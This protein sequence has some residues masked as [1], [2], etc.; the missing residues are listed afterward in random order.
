MLDR[1]LF[2]KLLILVLS[3]TAVSTSF[4]QQWTV[5]NLAG[6]G[7]EGFTPGEPPLDNGFANPG[8]ICRD[9]EGNIYFTVN[10]FD[11]GSGVSIFES[12]GIYKISADYSEI[13]MILD[14][15][16]SLTGVAVDNAGNV[17]FSKGAT[18]GTETDEY[19]LE[20]I[21][22]IQASDG[23]IIQFAGNGVD[24]IGSWPEEGA[25][26]TETPIG[27]AGALKIRVEEGKEFL[28]YCAT[29]QDNNFIQKIDI[30]DKRTFRVA[31]LPH[32]L[33]ADTY[34]DVGGG[35]P[36]LDTEI[37]LALGLAWDSQGNLYYS[38]AISDPSSSLV[39]G[40]YSI[41]KIVDGQI[42]NVAGNGTADYSGD[43][44]PALA[45]GLRKADGGLS[46]VNDELL[47]ADGLNNVIRKIDLSVSALPDGVITTVCGSGFEEDAAGNP[48]G[49][50]DNGVLK[51]ALEANVQPFDLIYMG[52]DKGFF[53]TDN[54][55]RIRRV[56]N[57]E[58]AVVNSHSFS[59][60]AI[61]TGD[62][63]TITL[64]AD[65]ND[66][67]VWNWY[68]GEC[69]LGGTSLSNDDELT[70]KAEENTTF[71]V[72]ATGGCVIDPECEAI[73]VNLTCKD[74]FNTFTPN[75]DGKNDFLEIPV[76]DNYP[77]NQVI[78]Y[79]RWGDLLEQID[80]YDNV[81]QVWR[82]TNG[83]NDPVDSGT[84][85]FTATSEGNLIASGW[86]QLI[87]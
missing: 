20:Y 49:D 81:T 57:C 35:E 33:D 25:I 2:F 79:N 27:N 68:E 23:E 59:S 39:D 76:L 31:G 26:I 9:N 70:F 17:Y 86:I 72:V 54:A 1:L 84:Y 67:T 36:A 16:F 37:A 74:Y 50:V 8:A 82:G 18:L 21:Y 38:T 87:K 3:S 6:T 65:I 55:L 63:I 80:N 28:Y 52:E 56:F 43:G 30:A 47:F 71:Y 73:E 53:F 66:A 61:C 4:S 5:E 64:D 45:A 11:F 44:L 7:S 85:Y 62:D 51:L 29:L 69:D 41:K 34:T 40:A 15:A 46:I 42:Y 10:L 58:P 19:S 13:E 12:S 24:G 32:T 83:G 77:N 78:V 22:K 60:D 14:S 48:D 75:D